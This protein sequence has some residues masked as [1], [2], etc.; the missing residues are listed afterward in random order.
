MGWRYELPCIL[1]GDFSWTIYLAIDDGSLSHQPEQTFRYKNE[2]IA[3]VKQSL[4]AGDQL[5]M[6]PH[7]NPAIQSFW[8]LGSEIR[9]NGTPSTFHFH[10]NLDHIIDIFEQDQIKSSFGSNVPSSRP[11]YSHRPSANSMSPS[12]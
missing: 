3:L 12:Q 8:D 2:T 11:Q 10:L 6:D 9:S 4:G 5:Q 1:N 7:P